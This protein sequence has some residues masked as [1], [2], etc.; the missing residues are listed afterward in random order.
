MR[1]VFIL[2]LCSF[3]FAAIPGAAGGP[4]DGPR[5]LDSIRP[6]PAGTPRTDIRASVNMT[7]VPVT[8]LDT[9]GRNVTGLSR[10]NFRVFDG[11][12][13][14]TI[15]SFSQQDQ[16]ISVGLVF[17]CSRSMSDKFKTERLAPMELY[18]Q[19]NP[20]DESFLI[21]VSNKP[22]LRQKYTSSFNE[23]E[24]AL[25]FT[26]PNGTT[27]LL[28]GVY[29]GLMEL[30]KAHNPRKALVVVS[31]GGDNSSRYTLGELKQLAVESD[32]QIF[33]IGLHQNPRTPEETDGPELLGRLTQETGGVNYTIGDINDLQKA[34][35]QIG[36]TLHN[37]YVLGYYPPPNQPSGK[38]R[39][40]KV[41]LI[42][43]AG[44]PKLLLFA[45]SGYYVPDR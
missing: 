19:L 22:E 29:M 27:P 10:D 2:F 13:P 5:L 7:L 26:H 38:Y 34:M 41:K 28:D 4:T 31:D 1:T 44:L 21:T 11:T 40:I 39:K 37:Q 35:T 32:A 42:V 3:V 14:V 45:R 24:N 17:D 18:K 16:P 36:V 33:A 25:I 8:V 43:P 6:L 30:K 20:T 12:K 15:A 9:M 23:I